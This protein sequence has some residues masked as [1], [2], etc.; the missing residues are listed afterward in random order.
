MRYQINSAKI[1]F[2]RVGEEGVIYD[3]ENNE[4]V[5]LNET[6]FKIFQ[7]IETGL[8][9]DGIVLNLCEEYAISE[10]ACRKDVLEALRTF[11]QRKFI[12]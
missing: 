8:D 7:G 5:S 1:L 12:L 3:T 6:F 4:F 2:T 9:I 11:V 10:E